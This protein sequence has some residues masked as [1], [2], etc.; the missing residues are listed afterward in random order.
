M[1]PITLFK[2]YKKATFELEQLNRVVLYVG[3]EAEMEKR[4]KLRKR[5]E[6]LLHKLDLR[7]SYHLRNEKRIYSCC[8]ICGWHET[9]CGCDEFRPSAE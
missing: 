2:A 4:N 7:L 8:I 5:Y 6:R 9:A 1:K 3:Q